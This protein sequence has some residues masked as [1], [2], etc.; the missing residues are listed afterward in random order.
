MIT[1]K[2]A[3]GFYSKRPE[4][5]KSNT[6]PLNLLVPSGTSKE[7]TT[8]LESLGL[9][10]I[11]NKPTITFNQEAS[12][13]GNQV[14]SKAGQV[15]GITITRLVFNLKEEVTTIKAEIATIIN[16][17]NAEN[18]SGFS[19]MDIVQNV[20]KVPV[21]QDIFKVVKRHFINQNNQNINDDINI[22]IINGNN[23]H[24]ANEHF[25]FRNDPET[26]NENQFPNG[27]EEL[28]TN[29]KVSQIDWSFDKGQKEKSVPI[30][31]N[32][33]NILK[34]NGNVF[35]T[36]TSG[37]FP[38]QNDATIYLQNDNNMLQNSNDDKHVSPNNMIQQ[39]YSMPNQY[40]N[41]LPPL[42]DNTMM[43]PPVQNMNM[44]PMV[45]NNMLHG[46]YGPKPF[47]NMIP[48]PF[49]KHRK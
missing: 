38:I 4:L 10:N 27:E 2:K 17:D 44:M 37:T 21:I 5:N 33:N 31:L 30:D 11:V 24:A 16:H 29:N 28:T 25:I 49:L 48:M 15:D 7:Q 43:I 45:D 9:Q 26:N 22:H 39:V 3:N 23:N 34:Q 12:K 32:N 13:T 46:P 40:N 47:N 19:I 6:K 8:G 1:T 35:P 42:L 20:L 14:A 36:Q 18:Q 41:V